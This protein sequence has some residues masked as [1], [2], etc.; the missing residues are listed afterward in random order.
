MNGQLI[1]CGFCSAD[2][3][4]GWLQDAPGITQSALDGSDPLASETVDLFMSIVGAEAGANG[5]RALATGG[6][7][8]C[9]GILPRASTHQHRPFSLISV[10][11]G[12]WNV[13][14]AIMWWYN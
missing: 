7:F 6:I 11:L 1:I 2:S 13:V 10:L 3:P 5:L 12:Q 14:F 8:L 4:C 9:G